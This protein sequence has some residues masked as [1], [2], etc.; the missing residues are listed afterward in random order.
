M[1]TDE[2]FI[3]K[4]KAQV[5]SRTGWGDSGDWTNQDFVALSEKIH[6]Q[7]GVTLS[8]VTLKRI[9]GKV[10]YDSLP[11]T[12]TLNTL[13]RYAGYENWREFKSKNGNGNGSSPRPR[14]RRKRL[15]LISG[16]FLGLIVLI[17][18]IALIPRKRSSLPPPIP[19]DYSFST[20]K[21]V[22]VGLPNSVIF[23]YDAAKA[24]GD[25]VIIQQSWDR[26]LRAT[27]AKD[28]HQHTCIYYYPDF[29][30]AKLIVGDRIVKQQ[31]LFIQTDGWLSLV[32][33][34]PVPV[35]FKKEEIITGGRMSLSVAQLRA[36]N[37]A[38]QPTPPTVLFSNVRDFGEIYSDDFVFETTLKDD[39]AEG[40]SV[41]QSTRI[42]LLCQGTAIWVPLCA[43]GCVSDLDLF[44]TGY[45]ASGKM[46][47]LSAFGVDFSQDTRVRIESH[48]GVAEL[49]INGKLAYR[50]DH[51]IQRSKIIGIEFQFQGTGSVDRV[52]LSNGKQ[53]YE[54]EF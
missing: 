12:H 17:C 36:K 21:T 44:F 49:L 2:G 13:A 31:S 19:A 26:N 15:F 27:V 6:D 37:I 11:N 9:W 43:K 32:A 23:D 5:E 7:T 42:Y 51:S 8:H 3:E 4:A 48:R 38:L 18:I 53:R 45:Y 35:Y 47:D 25:S 50:I 10:K 34:S 40:S 54:D 41:C 33:Q 22:S 20:K 28:Q 52:S 30:Y 29:F 16:I 46:E 1:L 14:A 24:P 39:Y